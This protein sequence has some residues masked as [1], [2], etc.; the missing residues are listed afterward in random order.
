MLTRLI[1]TSRYP[2][3]NLRVP[4]PVRVRSAWCRI[5]E[6]LSGANLHVFKCK[7]F[8]ANCQLKLRMLRLD[9]LDR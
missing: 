6:Y 3:I 2:C 9:C 8:S 7:A 5:V 4:L 1:S